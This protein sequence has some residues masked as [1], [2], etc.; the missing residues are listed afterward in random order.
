M[1]KWVRSQRSMIGLCFARI[2]SHEARNMLQDFITFWL[3]YCKQKT[4]S[5]VLEWFLKK[6]LITATWHVE[7]IG[8]DN[9]SLRSTLHRTTLKINNSDLHNLSLE[10]IAELSSK[11]ISYRKTPA[12]NPS[13]KK[14]FHNLAWDTFQS[15]ISLISSKQKLKQENFH[16][17]LNLNPRLE[18]FWWRTEENVTEFF[19]ILLFLLFS[20]F[21]S[22]AARAFL[23]SRRTIAHLQLKR[24]FAVNFTLPTTACLSPTTSEAFDFPKRLQKARVGKLVTSLQ[25]WKF[26][27]ENSLKFRRLKL[28]WNLRCS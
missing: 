19:S 14:N 4:I 6:L 16:L 3:R 5:R 23:N 20:Q 9:V 17:H 13:S 2:M 7:R 18:Q 25:N 12:K 10:K 27:I 24:C 21:F 26:L 15:E 28:H 22:F 11:I 1:R 8:T